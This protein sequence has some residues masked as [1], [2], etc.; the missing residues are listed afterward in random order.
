[1][2][3]SPPLQNSVIIMTSYQYM[4]HYVKHNVIHKTVIQHNALLPD[5]DQA[6]ATGTENFGH[7]AWGMQADRETDRHADSQMQ[8][9]A[10][11][12]T[13]WSISVNF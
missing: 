5:E 7:M 6:T 12:G 3:C 11:L 9:P 1:M 10:P 4:T 2:H 8:Y 13:E